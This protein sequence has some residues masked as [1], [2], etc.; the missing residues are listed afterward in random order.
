[1]WFRTVCLPLETRRNPADVYVWNHTA[2][3]DVLGAE[4]DLTC[5]LYDRARNPCF[6]YY[7][8][9]DANRAHPAP[10]QGHLDPENRTSFL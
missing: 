8:C 5:L 1:M 4:F 7:N 3:L 6:V 10:L 2:K 9:F